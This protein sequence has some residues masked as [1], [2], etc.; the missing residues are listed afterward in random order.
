MV[1]VATEDDV[2]RRRGDEGCA[3]MP[4]DPV[5][6]P[7]WLAQSLFPIGHRLHVWNVHTFVEGTC[8]FTDAFSVRTLKCDS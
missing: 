6:G 3:S 2:H 1:A 8:R 7:V 5:V 4:S